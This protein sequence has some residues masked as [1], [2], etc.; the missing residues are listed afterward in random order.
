MSARATSNGIYCGNNALSPEL[1]RNGG[2]RE[3]G[4]HSQCTAKG[5][6]RGFNQ[7]VPDMLAFLRHWS[8]KYEPHV[9]Q[10][11]YYGDG[12][13][14]PP[15]YQR[16]TLSQAAQRG[17]AIGALARARKEKKAHGSASPRRASVRNTVAL[18]R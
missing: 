5:Y 3:F 11:L 15:G 1:R 4:S 2:T 8:G 13:D 12:P 16:A 17:Y 6:A 14:I 7:P 10:R 18:P 9:V